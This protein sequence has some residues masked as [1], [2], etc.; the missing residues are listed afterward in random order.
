MT[1]TC[2][3]ENLIAISKAVSQDSYGKFEDN[4]AIA[5]AN[6]AFM[7]NLETCIDKLIEG[8][9]LQYNIKLEDT[10]APSGTIIRVKNYLFLILFKLGR[11]LNV[12]LPNKRDNPSY[13]K[14]LKDFLFINSR[15]F[16]LELYQH[17]KDT[18][19]ICTGEKDNT[20]L[21][22][23]VQKLVLQPEILVECLSANVR[24]NAYSPSNVLEQSHKQYGN[25]YYSIK[26]EKNLL[27][28]FA[29]NFKS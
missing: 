4:K 16:N 22:D 20:I 1:F 3:I 24:R 26:S 15:H 21:V 23:I 5:D 28:S 6:I 11:Y 12:Y 19:S 13:K 29:L 8:Y 25:P 14:Y 7:E 10:N 9:N 2:K 18:I 17:L 27:N